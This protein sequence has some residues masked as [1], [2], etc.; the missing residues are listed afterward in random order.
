MKRTKGLTLTELIVVVVVIVLVV[1]VFGFLSPRYSREYHRQAKCQ[2]NLYGIYR[3]FAMYGN[4]SCDS[5]PMLPDIDQATAKYDDDL[6][7]GD[8]CTAAALG[9]GAQQN[10]CLL[11][12]IRVIPWKFFLCPSDKDAIEAD[13]T[14]VGGKFGLGEPGKLYC[15]YGIQIPYEHGGDNKCPLTTPINGGV[16]FIGDR[17]P[18][19]DLNRNWSRNHPDYGESVLYFGGNV[20][21]SK[22]KNSEDDKNTAGWGGNN[23]YTRDNWNNTDPENPELLSNGSAVGYPASTKD[24][25]LYSWEP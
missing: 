13:R 24:T 11:V 7:M 14:G 21:F 2:D 4:E 3:G 25:V 6:Q 23:I 8:E 12:H 16:A 18:A 17:A 1:V 10:L 15:S 9:T 5:P 20:K 19:G 22:D